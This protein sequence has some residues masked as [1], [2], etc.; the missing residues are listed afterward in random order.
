MDA[1]ARTRAILGDLVSYP[2]VSADGNLELVAYAADHLSSAGAR[3][4]I[5]PDETG[6][7]AN[8]FATLG[9]EGDGGIILSGHTDVVPV[10]GQDW[11]NDPFRVIER[12]GLLFGRGTCDMKGFVAA[13]L[14][15]TPDFAQANLKRPLHF[16]FTYDEEIG[17]FG[18]REL[19]K[20]IAAMGIRPSAAIIGEPT[21]MHV[22]EG[23]KGCYEYTTEFTGL[24]GHGSAPDRGV[25]AIE[26]AVRY[27]ARLLEL[28]EA[29][30]ERADPA[31]RFEPPWPTLQ[32][33]RINGGV[34]RNIIAGQCAL[35]WEMRPIRHSEAEFIKR[36]M[37]SFVEQSLLPAMR[38]VHPD[39]GII[40]HV[41]G[42][43][44]G[45]AI[46]TDSEARDL[47]FALTGQNEAGLVPF[48]TEAGLFQS[49]GISAVICGPGS[50]E[51]AH[52]PDEFIAIEQLAAC[53]GM[54]DDLGRRLSR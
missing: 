52:K 22:V 29:L 31:N 37:K 54:L 18:A 53:L 36:E 27:A 11:S 7:K 13:C 5:T 21:G 49:A 8:L 10:E 4:S 43:V 33:G 50:I 23:H 30:K 41:I 26:Y 20:Q 39:A 44:E 48:G 24:E 2:T 19:M 46:E 9:P 12:D 6:T 28:R 14:A 3:L 42:E 32:I 25:S 45:L 38:D 34:A 1:L 15:M 17:C 40:T 47:A 51:Q 16:A 35:E